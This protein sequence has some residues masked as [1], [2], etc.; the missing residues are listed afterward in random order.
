MTDKFHSFSP[1]FACIAPWRE[2]LRALVAA[3]AFVEDRVDLAALHAPDTISAA[4]PSP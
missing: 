4:L 2:I 1:T 3:G